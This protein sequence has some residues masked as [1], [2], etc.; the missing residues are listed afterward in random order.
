VTW[1]NRLIFLIVDE[2][3]IYVRQIDELKQNVAKKDAELSQLRA[4]LTEMKKVRNGL[5]NLNCFELYFCLSDW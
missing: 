2:E 3:E 1:K 5:D 4:D